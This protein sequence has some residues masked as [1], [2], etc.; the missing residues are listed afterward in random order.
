MNAPLRVPTRTLTLLMSCS[1]VRFDEIVRSDLQ[2]LTT[3]VIPPPGRIPAISGDSSFGPRETFRE[4]TAA[5][6]IRRPCR[7]GTAFPRE[8]ARKVYPQKPSAT[9]RSVF[10]KGSLQLFGI[11]IRFGRHSLCSAREQALPRR[12]PLRA[13]NLCSQ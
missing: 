3:R 4:S 8:R 1:F 5:L 13:K 7:R 10:R 2:T 6:S 12:R 9:Q 11:G